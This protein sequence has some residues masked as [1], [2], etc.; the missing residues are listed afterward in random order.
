MQELSSLISLWNIQARSRGQ[1]CDCRVK[2]N[3]EP[4]LQFSNE[5]MPFDLNLKPH[6][7]HYIEYIF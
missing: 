3:V 4:F 7:V 1:V 6:G 5:I 2:E